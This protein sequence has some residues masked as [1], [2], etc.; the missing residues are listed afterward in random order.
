MNMV[1][2]WFLQI[3]ASKIQKGVEYFKVKWINI[4]PQGST[5]EPLEHL[6][7]DATKAALMGFREAKAAEIA[8]FESK[9]KAARQGQ[10]EKIQSTDTEVDSLDEADKQPYIFHF[11]RPRSDVWKYFYSKFFDRVKKAEYAKCRFCD[12][13]IKCANTT[14]LNA[15]LT[16]KHADE[17]KND[18]IQSGKVS[19]ASLLLYPPIF[20][21]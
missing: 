21:I 14:N 7:G 10:L 13:A 6:R 3:E 18:K 1:L 2:V 12:S 17:M 11:R 16:A 5:W 4:S 8:A 20:R 19:L 9:K 15:H